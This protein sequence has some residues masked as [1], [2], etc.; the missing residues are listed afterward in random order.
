VNSIV[1]RGAAGDVRHVYHRAAALG[2]WTLE[3]GRLTAEVVSHDAFQLSQEPLTFVVHRESGVT[4]SWPITDVHMD[5]A[6]LQ[7]SLC[8]QQGE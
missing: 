4:W 7:A 1:L 2:A 3:G 5:G 8:P 6:T